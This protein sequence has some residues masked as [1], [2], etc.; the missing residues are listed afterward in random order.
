M[1]RGKCPAISR[2]VAARSPEARRKGLDDR[3][4]ISYI[5][6]GPAKPL[7]LFTFNVSE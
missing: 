5:V 6:K 3:V 2:V 1:I 4:E 7:T